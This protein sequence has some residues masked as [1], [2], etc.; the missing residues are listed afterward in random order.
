MSAVVIDENVLIVAE[1]R[2][3]EGD[4][5]DEHI[6]SCIEALRKA[7]TQRIVL[8]TQNVILRK[9]IKHFK[10]VR[11]NGAGSE[12]LIWLMEGGQHM[13]ERCERV[14]IT[15]LETS[16]AE[17]PLELRVRDAANQIFDLDDHIWLAVAKASV[18]NPMIL[19]ATDTDWHHWRDRLE[20]HGFQIQFLCPELMT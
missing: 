14:T 13:S 5:L 12:F 17:V 10:P 20:A 3:P 19:N 16:F 6:R 8:D 15:P 7:K 4:L 11:N 18:N 1:K 2:M 9:Y